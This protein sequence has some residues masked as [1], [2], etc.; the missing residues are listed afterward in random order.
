MANNNNNNTDL[1]VMF[2][3]PVIFSILLFNSLFST[4][5]I[6]LSLV[7]LTQLQPDLTLWMLSSSLSIDISTNQHIFI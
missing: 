5:Y 3:A 2:F 1:L 6:P 7:S 4:D